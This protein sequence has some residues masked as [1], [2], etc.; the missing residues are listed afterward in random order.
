MIDFADLQNE[1]LSEVMLADKLPATPLDVARLLRRNKKL[2]ETDWITWIS[3]IITILQVFAEF[4]A[5]RPKP[6]E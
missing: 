2:A 3:L 6:T 1:A 5:N 4:R